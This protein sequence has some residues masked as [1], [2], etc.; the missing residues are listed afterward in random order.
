MSAVGC[1]YRN[2][3]ALIVAGGMVPTKLAF[4]AGSVLFIVSQV[5]LPVIYCHGNA[6]TTE[7]PVSI[8]Q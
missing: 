5:H 2:P 1:Y 8:R 6:R 7:F 4:R 3:L